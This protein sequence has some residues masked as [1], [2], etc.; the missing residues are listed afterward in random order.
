[1]Y[2]VSY[3]K[4]IILCLSKGAIAQKGPLVWRVVTL[5][6]PELEASGWGGVGGSVEAQASDRVPPINTFQGEESSKK[7]QSDWK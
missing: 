4:N 6:E 7:K 2:F 1:M 5:E 3:F